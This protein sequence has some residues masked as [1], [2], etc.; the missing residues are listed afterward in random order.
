M[1]RAGIALV[2]SRVA[3]AQHRPCSGPGTSA[4]QSLVAHSGDSRASCRAR[5]PAAEG[6]TVGRH[7]L[8]SLRRNLYRASWLLQ[9]SL[10]IATASMAQ[11]P[12]EVFRWPSDHWANELNETSKRNFRNRVRS[13]PCSNLGKY[14]AERDTRAAYWAIRDAGLFRDEACKAHI[15]SQVKES[16]PLVELAGTF[17]R[18][19]MGDE[20]E[21][22]A[23]VDEFDREAS[24]VP[25]HLIVE[26]F[27]FIE[28]W[29]HAGRRLARHIPRV[30]GA[31]TTA[32]AS[33]F[34]W[35]R[36]LYGD[37]ADYKATCERIAHEEQVAAQWMPTMCGAD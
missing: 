34:E 4:V 30:D 18:Y 13:F 33:A 29:E 21:L 16:H 6:P 19:R 22:S 37:R 17:Y 1:Q 5:G 12:P 3:A 10:L 36:F 11:A 20:H 24:T 15:D 14:L 9:A 7:A 35:K 31:A 32:L 2:C 27:G 8:R 28:D 25:D 23:L 26:L